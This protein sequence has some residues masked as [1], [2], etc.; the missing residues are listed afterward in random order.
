MIK[1]ILLIVLILF[2]ILSAVVTLL[3]RVYLPIKLKSLIIKGLESQTHK[4]VSL[5]R[6]QFSLF[7][8]LVLNDLTIRD[9][10]KTIISIKEA[11]CT[12]FIWPFIKKQI[13]I[14]SITIR[15]ASAYIERRADNTFNIIELFG[16]KQGG[17]SKGKASEFNFIISKVSV[18]SSKVNFQDNAVAPVFNN[19]FDDINLTLNLSLPAAVKFNLRAN[20]PSKNSSLKLSASGQYRILKKEL[21]SKIKIEDLSPADFAGYYQRFWIL[22]A[23][24]LLDAEATVSLKND[25]LDINLQA[26]SDELKFLA[27]LI[28]CAF[29]GDVNADFEYGIKSKLLNYSGQLNILNAGISGVPSVGTIKNIS[30]RIDFSNAGLSSEK[31]KAG[32]FDIP[33]EAKLRVTDFKKPLLNISLFAG[34]ELGQA[35]II[36]SEKFKITLPVEIKGNSRLVLSLESKLSEKEKAKING[37][38]EVSDASL[39]FEKIKEPFEEINGKFI[40]D[41][42]QLNWQDLNF[43]F[44]GTDYISKGTLSNFQAPTVT[45]TLDGGNLSLKS[46]FREQN[47]FIKIKECAGKYFNSDLSFSGDVNLADSLHPQLEISGILGIDLEDL[48]KYLKS[49]KEQL[50]KIKPQGKV[51]VKFVLSGDPKNLK[52]CALK[53]DLSSPSISA[54]G[55]RSGDLSMAY[56]QENGIVDIKEMQL[57]LYEGLLNLEAR[58]NLNSLNM[59]LLANIAIQG[60]KIEKLKLDTPMKDKDISGLIQAQLK[61]DGFLSNLARLRGSG[62]ILITEGKLW[63]LDLFKGMGKLLFTSDFSSIVFHQAACNFLLADQ[64]ISSDN[65]QLKSNLLN[66]DGGGRIGFDGTIDLALN[67]HV[68]GDLPL[69]GSVKDIAAVVLSQAE[70]FGVIRITGTL[71]E[72]KYHFEASVVDIMD[73]IK[74]IFWKNQ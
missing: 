39:K 41:S 65:L 25:L 7:K 70:K 74:N 55:L 59:P 19:G 29:K 60:V 52:L 48:S 2:V 47:K 54:Y 72:P 27:G 45:L 13:V 26:D 56:V 30:G 15:Q 23:Q 22:L 14:P 20:M 12:F 40:F 73:S 28:G 58:V 46:A 31:L 38:L 10:D 51:Q 36:L 5:G 4:Q 57:S 16:S 49:H 37:T 18:I 21:S 68:S 8:G 53:A 50:A 63:Q 9:G 35:K 11:D 61:L 66:I 43:K 67:A 42:E 6:L 71:K 17:V 64:H 69:S 32:I 44:S 1:K 34:P 33:V 3:N 62:Q 24:G